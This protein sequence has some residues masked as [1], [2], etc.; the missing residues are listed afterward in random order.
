MG[1]A[2]FG[3]VAFV[4]WRGLAVGLPGLAKDD[5]DICGMTYA[6]RSTTLTLTSIFA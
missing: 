5:H 3:A 2:R 1:L 6:A 4:E